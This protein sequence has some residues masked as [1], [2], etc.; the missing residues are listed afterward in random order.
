M[1]SFFFDS[2][3]PQANYKKRP[4]FR[5]G[6]FT[7]GDPNITFERRTATPADQTSYML[8]PN[9][10]V[11]STAAFDQMLSSGSNQGLSGA[12]ARPQGA[13]ATPVVQST[14]QPAAPSTPYSERMDQSGQPQP[15]PAVA[16]PAAQPVA[17]PAAAQ[18]QPKGPA[19]TAA[20]IQEMDDVP[21]L[22]GMMHEIRSGAN[23][24]QYPP[25]VVRSLTG[26]IQQ[27]IA[28][29][30]DRE[31]QAG[32]DEQRQRWADQ[33]T[34]DDMKREYP[35]WAAW[36]RSNPDID[37]SDDLSFQAFE[38]EMANPESARAFRGFRRLSA[39]KSNIQNQQGLGA[40]RNAADVANTR[41]SG[42]AVDELLTN[43][44]A[45]EEHFLQDQTNLGT[46]T[47]PAGGNQKLINEGMRT[48]DLGS[49]NYALNELRTQKAA[50][51]AARATPQ[52]QRDEST[53]RNLQKSMMNMGLSADVQMK[54]NSDI[55]KGLISPQDAMILLQRL[56]GKA[57]GRPMGEVI[58]SGSTLQSLRQASD[59]SRAM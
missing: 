35:M 52:Y 38:K 3:N 56:R 5:K 23:G 40:G 20:E 4:D 47:A 43:I 16:Q 24:A 32:K 7:A 10:N 55:E 28:R 26:L 15:Q 59:R 34:R 37:V 58:P 45:P 53:Y 18:V 1:S 54:M 19:D 12:G 57:P 49:Q 27:R 46:S 39:M 22:I 50:N 25:E 9:A 48:E 31:K 17:K 51:D 13:A 41:E 29:I 11:F 33:R 36:K 44:G 14:T 8:S 2:R 42:K 6:E 21:G 30:Q